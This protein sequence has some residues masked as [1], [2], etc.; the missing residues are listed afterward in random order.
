MRQV[1]NL[2]SKYAKENLFSQNKKSYQSACDCHKMCVLFQDHIVANFS[3]LESTSKYPGTLAVTE[4]RQFRGRG[5]THISDEA[6]VFF[7]EVEALR[8]ELLNEN[9]L[10]SL[11][12]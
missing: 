9:R 2:K 7:L 8:V 3:N 5:L 12:E 6:Y 4:E 1:V 11:K 10:R